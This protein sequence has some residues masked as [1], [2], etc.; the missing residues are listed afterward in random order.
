MTHILPPLPYPKGALSP[1][2]S[3]ETLDFHYGKHHQAYVN[4]LNLLL[5]KEESMSSLKQ[6]SLEELILE[7]KGALF[8]NASQVWNH[9]F[10]WNTLTPKKQDP[11]PSLKASL[12]KQF[13]SLEEFKQAFT[14]Q[15]LALFGSGWTW[16]VKTEGESLE[17]INT[18]NADNPKTQGLTPLITCDVWEHA[19]YIDYRNARVKY[20]DSFWNLINWNFLSHNLQK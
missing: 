16:L 2:I 6:A 18:F 3:E 7:A 5:E 20:L 9:H 19:Y 14:K 17:I 11:E 1:Y 8:N 13:G 15:A 4:K 12:E 10:Y